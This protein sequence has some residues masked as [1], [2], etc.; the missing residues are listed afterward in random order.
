MIW[1]YTVY[2]TSHRVFWPLIGFFDRE[3]EKSTGKQRVRERGRH[4]AKGCDSDSMPN[5]IPTVK[6]GVGC[7][8]L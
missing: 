4:A 8:M 6:H 1:K 5:A 7:I 2:I 3:S